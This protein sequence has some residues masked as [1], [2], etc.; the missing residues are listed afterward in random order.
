V[1]EGA[2]ET[3]GTA[4]EDRQCHDCQEGR[5]MGHMTNSATV[6]A[7]FELPWSRA[8]LR[9]YLG[10]IFFF[11][12]GIGSYTLSPNVKTP[13]MCDTACFSVMRASAQ[14]MKRVMIL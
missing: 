1:V 7:T 8:V 6:A 12:F 14:R 4:S 3:L 10:S 11:A 13:S 2:P 9:G 5:F